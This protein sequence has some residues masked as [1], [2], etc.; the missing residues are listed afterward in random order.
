MITAVTA[1]AR[2]TSAKIPTPTE[3]ET[4]WVVAQNKFNGVKNDLGTNL[5]TLTRW[6]DFRLPYQF[7][8]YENTRKS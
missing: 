8:A 6:R 3:T 4:I 5:Y 7:V 2:A 1:S